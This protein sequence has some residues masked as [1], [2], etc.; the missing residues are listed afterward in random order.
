VAPLLFCDLSDHDGIEQGDVLRIHGLR[1]GLERGEH[2]YTVRNLTRDA[3]FEVRHDVSDRQVRVLLAGGLINDFRARTAAGQTAEL[4]CSARS[5]TY[6]N[7]RQAA[8]ELAAERPG[9][10]ARAP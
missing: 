9:Q 6:E 5:G 7:R 2:T 8:S 3:T 1:K 10:R 4:P